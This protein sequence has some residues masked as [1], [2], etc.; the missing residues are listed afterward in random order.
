MARGRQRIV[1]FAL[2][3]V[4]AAHLPRRL[5]AAPPRQATDQASAQQGVPA[6]SAEAGTNRAGSVE[7]REGCLEKTYQGYTLF[8]DADD[9]Y[10]VIAPASQLGRYASDKV[11]ITGVVNKTDPQSSIQVQGIKLIRRQLKL[12]PELGGS[13]SRDY[14]NRKYGVAMR[15]PGSF[16]TVDDADRADPNF[17][18]PNFVN[19][20]GVVNLGAIEI[21]RSIYPNST[22]AHGSLSVSVSN[23]IANAPT[24]NVFREDGRG[25]AGSR[26]IHGVT[27]SRAAIG[28]AAA[29]TET[30]DYYFHTYQHARCYEVR[31]EIAVGNPMNLDQPCSI[32]LVNQDALVNGLL[33]KVSYFAP[34]PKKTL[35]KNIQFAA[36]VVT[37]FEST[38]GTA[39]AASMARVEVSWSTVGADYVRIKCECGRDVYVS[40]APMFYGQS[41]GAENSECWPALCDNLTAGG[42]VAIDFDNL[43]K[44]SVPIVLTV[45]PFSGGVG[46][47][48][49]SKTVTIVVNPSLFQ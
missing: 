47:P 28:S 7:V 44:S 3:L 46:D 21:P 17:G 27:Y 42:F 48:K 29:G 49:W 14:S 15:Y 6:P 33:A 38:S 24:C 45:Q 4:V 10:S 13:G 32:D 22:F 26:T 31:V 35:A 9:F 16:E 34:R 2:S 18:S 36:P 39:A 12:R 40:A 37:S 30:D 8:G 43:G 5:D 11:R 25:S 41:G 20:D 19:P 23:E 1:L